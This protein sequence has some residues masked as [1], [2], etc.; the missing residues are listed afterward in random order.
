MMPYFAAG[1]QLTNNLAFRSM[2]ELQYDLQD[3]WTRPRLYSLFY[4]VLST[5]VLKLRWHTL[6]STL[7]RTLPVHCLKI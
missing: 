2:V 5:R 3:D 6:Y 7:R 4:Q 1:A